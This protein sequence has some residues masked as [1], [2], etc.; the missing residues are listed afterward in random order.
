MHQKP[1][2]GGSSRIALA[3]LLA[4]VAT[5]AL[6]AASTATTNSASSNGADAVAG[7][8]SATSQTAQSDQTIYVTAPPLFGDIL[9]ER[10]LD[11]DAIDSYGASTVDDILGEVQAEL[12]DDVAPL[13]IVNGQ[14]VNDLS[15][16]GALPVEAL[17]SIV[18][19]PRGSAVR[20][21]GTA[22][23]RVISITLNRHLR[24]ATLTAAHKV[25]TDGNWNADRGQ[26]M[27]TS[28]KGDTRA[29]LTFRVRDETQL[30]ESQ[31][32]VIQP[33]PFFPFA[34]G[35][36]IIGFPDTTGEIDP[37]LSALAGQ[38]VTVV[39]VPSSGAPTLAQLG[40]TANQQN[41]TDLGLFRTLRPEVRNY[42]IN[43]SVATRL[44]PWLTVN[45]TLHWSR[46]QSNY[47]RGLPF[48]LF[49][50]SPTNPSSPFSND[51]ALAI[52][53]K[54]PLHSQSTQNSADG[55]LTFNANWGNWQG[56][57]NVSHSE[58]KFDFSTQHQ[59]V[60]GNIPIADSVDPFT[61]DLTSLIALQTDGTSS[62]SVDTLADLTLDGPILTLPAGSVQAVFE[63]RLGWN[64]LKTTSTFFGFGNA[65]FRRDE[66]SLRSGLEIPLTNRDGFLREIGDLSASVEYSR[67]HFSDVGSVNHYTYG[68][69]WEPRPPLRLH[70]S[71]DE[72]DRPAPIQTIGNPVT[73]I[74]DVRIFDPL[75]G[76]TV[77]VTEISGG[78]PFLLPE[79]TRLRDVSALVRLV[80]R[81]NLELNAEY[82]D[83]DIRNFVAS[84]PE[85][86]AAIELAFP[87][88][89]IRDSNG[90]LT[91]VDLRPVNFDSHREKR[92]RWGLSMN[93]KIA[94]GTA[95]AAL[96]PGVP[97][98]AYQPPTYLELTFNHTMVFS[99]H[100]LIR[101]ELDSVDLLHGG[102]IG[103]GGGRLRHQV[104]GTAAITSGGVGIRMGVTWRG[105][106]ELISQ[107]NGV[108]DTLH[109]SP[110]L[111][112]NVRAFAD[113]KRFLPHDHW[114]RG[115]RLSLDVINVTNKRQTVHDS[116][117][118]T[119]LQFQ[120]ALRD[121]LG[122]TI[123]VELRKVF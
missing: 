99:D 120:P 80:P 122:R 35:G 114:A 37:L 13:L 93:T 73:I 66:Q 15:D 69:T 72:T 33:A 32:D 50:L 107:F 30:L 78:N 43:G 85:A 22:T 113:L 76:Q 42:D 104:D 17:H 5:P 19:L 3:V 12:G 39:P 68:L 9:P 100:I 74:P 67:T 27:L 87:D 26:A 91:T 64:D 56:N 110:L 89:F 86:S 18:V 81:L 1:M 20:A 4:T 121:P 28:V 49:V 84:L 106:S 63:G 47:L 14:R 97:R 109:F 88:R 94:A 8:Q 92:F 103:I 16:I 10:S 119:P 25:S 29:N 36:N 6:T 58:S 52:F 115:L 71:I 31:R 75:T 55:N 41:T 21:G 96:K 70:A 62:R 117:G 61:T 57:L 54:N 102:A 90:V 118:N 111:A 51:V 11:Q 53:G 44:A 123:E 105:P 24:T 59:T 40:A 95:G 98:P 60:F 46:N 108:T 116:F 2:I 23:Q 7:T 48:A 38:T 77:D 79:K 82:I 45:A 101:P 65:A 112:I 83:S 34:V